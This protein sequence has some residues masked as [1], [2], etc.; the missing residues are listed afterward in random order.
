[1]DVHLMIYNPLSSDKLMEIN[2]NHPEISRVQRHSTH[3]VRNDA[4]NFQIMARDLVH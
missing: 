1:M 4:E 3:C 2:A